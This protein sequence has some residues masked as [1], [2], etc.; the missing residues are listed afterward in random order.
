MEGS[1]DPSAQGAAGPVQRADSWRD[2]VEADGGLNT[3]STLC[4][5]H[6]Q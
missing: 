1:T 5:T 2:E 3:L 6:N 4:T